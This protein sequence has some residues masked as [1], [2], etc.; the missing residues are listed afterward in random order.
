M[1]YARISAKL[2]I[3]VRCIGPTVPAAWP[4]H[5]AAEL[6]RAWSGHA[7]CPFR[8]TDS[9]PVTCPEMDDAAGP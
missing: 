7:G 4:R 5:G 1:P 9:H 2:G 3:P 8:V 6:A